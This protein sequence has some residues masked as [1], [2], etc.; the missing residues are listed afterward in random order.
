MVVTGVSALLIGAL[1]VALATT[2]QA[3]RSGSASPGR[4]VAKVM[5]QP[6]QSLW[7]VAEAHDPDAD[8]RLIVSEIEQLNSMTADQVRS[9]EYLWVPR[10]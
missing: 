10:G 8:T 6:G 1:S 7:S 9:G 3:T 4:Y 5:V 2:A